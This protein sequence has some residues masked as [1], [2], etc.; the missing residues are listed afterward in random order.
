MAM[1][2]LEKVVVFLPIHLLNDELVVG[3]NSVSVVLFCCG[4]VLSAKI[5]LVFDLPPPTGCSDL[6][7]ALD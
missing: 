6:P 1:G 3:A 2:A 5:A 4:E 7:T